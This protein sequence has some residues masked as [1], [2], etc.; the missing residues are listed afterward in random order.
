MKKTILAALLASIATPLHALENSGIEFTGYTR[1]G[2]YFSDNGTPRGGYT[3]GGDTQKFRLGNE[4]DSGIEV[5]LGKTFDATEGVKWS[6]LYM[7]AVWGGQYSTAQAFTT[8]WGL[9]FAPEAKFWAG[10]RR[11]RLN[12]VHIVD[13]F[14]MDYGDNNGAGMTDYNL[15]FAKLGVGVFSGGTFDNNSSTVNNASRAN[16]DLSEI[17]VSG[18]GKLR[19][20]A[21]VVRGSY[22]LGTPGAG[23]S[24]AHDQAHFIVENLSN[25]LFLQ[26]ANGHASLSGQFQGLSTPTN[27]PT[28]N[29]P[30]AKSFRI[31]DAIN[32]QSGMIGGQALVAYQ[33]SKDEGGTSDGIEKRDFTLGARVSYATS[34]NFKWLVEAGTTTR[35]VEGQDPQNLSKFTIAPTLAIAPEFSSRP[36]L[37]FYVTYVTWNN[38]AAA[39][40]AGTN[41]FGV[42]GRASSTLMGAQ[43]ETWW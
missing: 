17:K 39:A 16:I 21:T 14:F 19:L 31:A 13:R 23:L 26:S 11:L 32:W 8:I 24:L 41:G 42:G 12:D 37:R 9:D 15:G 1:G 27:A 20:L 33:T 30:G 25:T 5:G 4:G 28:T 2:A 7:P 10:Q 36:E 43:M 40:N 29:N 18:Y 6:V 34:R 35:T 3:L 38:A 22:Q